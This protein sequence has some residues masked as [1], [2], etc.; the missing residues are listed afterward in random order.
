MSNNTCNNLL[1]ENITSLEK[2]FDFYNDSEFNYTFIK[3]NSLN[4]STDTKTQLK[5]NVK[6]LKTQKEEDLYEKSIVYTKELVDK[7]CKV[8]YETI[9]K[10]SQANEI[11][12]LSYNEYV[13]IQL[14]YFWNEIVKLTKQTSDFS[15]LNT[16]ESIKLSKDTNE[17][18]KSF[19]IHF[20]SSIAI[21][22]EENTLLHEKVNRLEKQ[23]N[24]LE[25]FFTK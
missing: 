10:Q 4:S 3:T 6:F 12:R 17:S 16:T 8:L 24:R 5:N 1:N 18:L 25:N 23:L 14:K 2:D 15:E 11:F 13:N 19:T 9:L 20:L 22:K 7:N 21:L